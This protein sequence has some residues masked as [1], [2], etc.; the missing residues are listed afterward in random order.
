MAIYNCLEC[1]G[2]IRIKNAKGKR[3]DYSFRCPHCKTRQWLI[4]DGVSKSLSLDNQKIK[5]NNEENFSIYVCL[6]CNK[7]YKISDPRTEDAIKNDEGFMTQCLWC[8]TNQWLVKGLFGWQ[9]PSSTEPSIVDMDTPEKKTDE[10]SSISSIYNQQRIIQSVMDGKEFIE[11]EIDDIG[12]EILLWVSNFDISD[13][14]E[15]SKTSFFEGILEQSHRY[16]MFIFSA[17]FSHTT[18][19]LG[20]KYF[21][22]LEIDTKDFMAKCFGL[23]L[24]SLK[25]DEKTIPPIIEKVFNE[26]DENYWNMLKKFIAAY[27]IYINGDQQRGINA[28][29]NLIKDINKFRK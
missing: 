19:V 7:P 28:A 13:F 22:N 3:D 5:N 20:E 18:Y 12:S 25:V 21:E 4:V 29:K 27:K 2:L 23:I 17:L 15:E 24:E 16:H 14:S 11:S 9:E 10:K 6:K 8:D 26:N 1:N